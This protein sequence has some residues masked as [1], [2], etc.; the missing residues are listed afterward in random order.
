MIGALS[1]F[2]EISL[3]NL[4]FPALLYQMPLY[5]LFNLKIVP[6]FIPSSRILDALDTASTLVP[7]RAVPGYHLHQLKGDLKDFWA[8]RVTGNY[9]IIFQFEAGQVHDVDYLDYH[10]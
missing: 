6:H 2:P 8:V 3:Q 4:P 1:C 10:Y 5:I 7:L 9:R